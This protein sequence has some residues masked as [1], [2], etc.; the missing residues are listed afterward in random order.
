MPRNLSQD[1]KF[2]RSSHPLVNAILFSGSGPGGNTDLS[3]TAITRRSLVEIAQHAF[4]LEQ[5][6]SIFSQH[7]NSSIQEAP[8]QPSY[9]RIHTP[10]V[11]EP[12][13]SATDSDDDDVELSEHLNLMTLESSRNRFFGPSSSIMLVKTA[14]EA[15]LEI[16]LKE[17]EASEYDC[18]ANRRPEFWTVHPVSP[19]SA[20]QMTL[21][22]SLVGVCT[23]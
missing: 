17:H 22:L 8:A 9:I 13:V 15:Q 20:T 10:P 6:L 14:V 2:Q 19:V 11:T 7:I 3:D 23:S 1:R 12:T 16:S 21:T 5:Q 4:N 18:T